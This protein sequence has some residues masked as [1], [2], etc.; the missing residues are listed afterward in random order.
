M[1][2]LSPRFF[3]LAETSSKE[4]LRCQVRD[5]P[6]S[7]RD[8]L[9]GRVHE[10]INI[11]QR[12]GKN[13]KDFIWTDDTSILAVSD[14]FLSLLIR[15]KATGWASYPVVIKNN[16]GGSIEGYQGLA[17]TGRSGPIDLSKSPRVQIPPS[18][19]GGPPRFRRKGLPV[20][21]SSWDGSDLFVPT[22]SGYKLITERIKIAL[23]RERVSNVNIE[24]CSD[25]LL[26][27]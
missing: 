25:V 9:T 6:Y 14:K 4:A 15:L 12:W 19:D 18:Y 26:M 16:D 27:D 3:R 21:A 8:V 5:F 7:S 1:I 2:A 10:T 23:E 17:I 13:P 24:A 22:G 20:D 11:Y